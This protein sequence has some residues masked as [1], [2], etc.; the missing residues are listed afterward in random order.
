MENVVVKLRQM[1]ISALVIVSGVVYLFGGEPLMIK[2]GMSLA[3]I[4]TLVS[5]GDEEL[6]MVGPGQMQS[7]FKIEN[8]YKTVFYLIVNDDLTL[9]KIICSDPKFK[10]NGLGVDSSFS[11]ILRSY[12]T[13][14]VIYLPGYGRMVKVNRDL[15]FGFA[16][17]NE[18]SR[19]EILETERVSW[20]EMN[21]LILENGAS[22]KLI[23]E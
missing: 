6:M 15:T 14:E 11:D 21:E 3:H 4:R 9:S 16:W 17:N 1:F 20:V 22:Q 10:K 19:K 12:A 5:C 18:D 8:A 7:S 23:R 13:P 2:T